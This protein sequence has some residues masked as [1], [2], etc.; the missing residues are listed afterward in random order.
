MVS[1]SV[2]EHQIDKTNNLHVLYQTGPRSF[3]YSVV[4]PDGQ[5]ILR[6]THDYTATRPILRPLTEGRVVVAGGIRR[7]ALNDIPAPTEAAA[8]TND[9][10]TIKP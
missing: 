4:N 5:V 3:N 8:L 10:P 2:P 9:P 1:F 7:I 6:Q